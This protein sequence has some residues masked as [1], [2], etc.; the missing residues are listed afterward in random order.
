MYNC[1]FEVIS[2]QLMENQKSK[3]YQVIH[4]QIIHLSDNCIAMTVVI[5]IITVTR[6]YY[7]VRES[8]ITRLVNSL[9]IIPKNGI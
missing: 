9:I 5:I 7:L 3:V 6:T 4:S 2:C 8:F 1:N